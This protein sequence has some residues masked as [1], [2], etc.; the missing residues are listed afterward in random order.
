MNAQLEVLVGT[1]WRQVL[2][3]GQGAMMHGNSPTFGPVP[4][5]AQDDLWRA[6]AAAL[7]MFAG[8]PVSIATVGARGTETILFGAGAA[9]PF[10]CSWVEEK[11]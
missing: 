2:R 5:G 1:E 7:A 4:E 9:G 8:E 6:A 11:G 3:M 10:Q